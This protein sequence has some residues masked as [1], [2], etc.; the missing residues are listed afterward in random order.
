MTRT[1]FIKAYAER[2]KLS[3]D[4]ALLGFLEIGEK[5]MIALPCGCAE[6]GCEGWA[7][8]GVEHIDHHLQFYAPD[9]MAEVYRD[10]IKASGGV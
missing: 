5:T 3:S 6:E 10:T 4:Y 8:L 7:M 1:E 9:K 2:S